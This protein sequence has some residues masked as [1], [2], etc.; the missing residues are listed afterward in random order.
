M[1][2]H[3]FRSEDVDLSSGA[4]MRDPPGQPS[5]L[6]S[7]SPPARSP[8]PGPPGSV[9]PR[10]LQPARSPQNRYPPYA[11]SAPREYRSQQHRNFSYDKN[12]ENDQSFENGRNGRSKNLRQ[13]QQFPPRLA[14]DRDL[15][16]YKNSP[17]LIV[18]RGNGRSRTL[19]LL[20][21]SA[22][23]ELRV[24][25]RTERNP[26]NAQVNIDSQIHGSGKAEV[27]DFAQSSTPSRP[28]AHTLPHA[29][30]N[31]IPSTRI[32]AGPPK[33]AE[34]KPKYSDGELLRVSRFDT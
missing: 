34:S 14:H 8:P 12:V 17:R 31:S 18:Q 3:I 29:S 21:I 5:R 30:A 4:P 1:E 2:C 10:P 16:N 22:L 25:Y 19:R 15:G 23:A 24:N 7:R 28:T 20:K 11:S 33:A 27:G 6:K 13:H 26:I 32:T 9:A